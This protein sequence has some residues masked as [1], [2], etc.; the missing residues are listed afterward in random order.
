MP[1]TMIRVDISK[2]PEKQSEVIH[3]R[4]HPDILL[5]VMVKPGDEFRI[6]CLD[7]TGGQIAKMT[8]RMML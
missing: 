6:E 1:K 7:W 3:S 2:S 5:A 8:V 4:W